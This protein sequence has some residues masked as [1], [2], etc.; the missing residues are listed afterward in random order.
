MIRE[1]EGD[2][3]ALG[4]I[5]WEEFPWVMKGTFFLQVGEIGFHVSVSD[6]CAWL[7]ERFSEPC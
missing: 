5:S 1:I 6:C 4:A 3:Q 7:E 2:F